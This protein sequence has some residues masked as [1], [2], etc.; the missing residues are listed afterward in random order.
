MKTFIQTYNDVDIWLYK[1]GCKRGGKCVICFV[2]KGL[3]G[4]FEF[5]CGNV[6]DYKIALDETRFEI[7]KHEQRKE[8]I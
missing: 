2:T 6:L 1:L 7:D 5:E 8:K 4:Y 3:T